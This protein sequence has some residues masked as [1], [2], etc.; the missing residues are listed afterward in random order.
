M[1]RIRGPTDIP[2]DTHPQLRDLIRLRIAQLS[3]GELY[4]PDR[5]GELYFADGT[6]T[7]E[8]LEEATGVFIVTN[9]FDGLRFGHPDFAPTFE[10]AE[11][12]GTCFEVAFQMSDESAVAIFVPKRPS[13]DA[14][15]TAFC[16]AF[17][18]PA[19]V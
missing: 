17:A 15:L 3:D 1:I 19:V 7:A 4:D 12:H 10:F 18:V 13:I 9:P 11:E 2:S 8:S 16:A 5:H 6:D 14:E